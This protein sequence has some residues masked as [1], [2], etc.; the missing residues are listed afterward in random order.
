MHSPDAC[1]DGSIRECHVTLNEREG[2]LTC[3]AGNEECQGGAWGPCEGTALSTKSSALSSGS[4][5]A[6]F[7]GRRAL[8]V[9][10]VVDVLEKIACG[11]PDGD[12]DDDDHR[13]Y[14]S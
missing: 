1:E 14:Q 12:A 4:L 10:V 5:R 7:V 8:A 9:D 3:L 11:E 6:H 2:V 13:A